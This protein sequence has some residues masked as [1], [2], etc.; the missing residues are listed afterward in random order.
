MKIKIGVL[1]INGTLKASILGS[2]I[3]TATG[4][5]GGPAHNSAITGV[6]VNLSSSID[7]INSPDLFEVVLYWKSTS[8]S[9]AKV[10]NI[11]FMVDKS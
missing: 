7:L 8:G 5:S 6:N 4:S 1:G 3:E 10:T 2:D 9:S 11:N